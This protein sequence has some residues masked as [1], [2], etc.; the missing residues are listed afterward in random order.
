MKFISLKLVSVLYVRLKFFLSGDT[1]RGDYFSELIIFKDLGKKLDI[2]GKFF[3]I[4]LFTQKFIYFLRK[5]IYFPN[6]ASKTNNAA[7]LD[8]T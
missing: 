3:F 1:F 2:K 5:F 8:H 6:T 4:L 7:P